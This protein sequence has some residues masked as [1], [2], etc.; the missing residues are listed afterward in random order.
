MGSAK[1]I[2]VGVDGSP[3]STNA[4]RWAARWAA[5]GQSLRLVHAC[6]VPTE[7]PSEFVNL[8]D[9]HAAI[10]KRGEDVLLTAKQAA[11]EEV[12]GLR[13]ETSKEV[14][15]AVP[16]LVREAGTADLLVVGNR[17]LGGFLGLLVGSTSTA[18]AGRA[19][20]P[21]VVV[22]EGE[23]P[24][25][26][27]PI[28]VG[29]DGTRA[30]EDAIAFAFA[31]AA[32]RDAEL[33]AVHAWTDFVL[34]IAF[35]G[36]PGELDMSAVAQEA[37]AVLGERLAGWQEQYPDVR[38]KREV[39]RQPPAEALLQ[40]AANARLVVAGSRGRGGLR[41]LILGSTSQRLLHHAQCPIAVVRSTANP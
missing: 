26:A 10:V 25:A 33:I 20:C 2:V 41:G 1:P 16:T 13:V 12:P 35:A 27:G 21:V 4:V 7:Y 23:E 8:R 37:A 17:G 38:V 36:A 28:V 3:G 11:E 22:R 19:P 34:E 18:V 39:V 29:V 24:A 31:E 32:A 14:D 9:L 40:H 5:P 15:A 30:S 6:E